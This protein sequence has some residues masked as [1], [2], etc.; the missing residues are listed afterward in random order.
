MNDLIDALTIFRKYGNP[1]SPT[2]CEH[3]VMYV[4]IQPSKV[5]DEDKTELDRLGFF[6]YKEYG[7]FSSYRFGSA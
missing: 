3:D 4:Q 6:E 1:E 2:H 5:S 7:C